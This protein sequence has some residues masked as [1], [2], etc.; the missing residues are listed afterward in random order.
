MAYSPTNYIKPG[1][2][3]IIYKESEDQTTKRPIKQVYCSVQYSR[4]T[5]TE[6]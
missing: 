5:E 1:S 4:R 2:T 3:D 6:L